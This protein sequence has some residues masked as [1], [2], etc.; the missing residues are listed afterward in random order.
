MK[1]AD[2]VPFAVSPEPDTPALEVGGLTCSS[3]Q[4]FAAIGAGGRSEGGGC[5]VRSVGLAVAA[6]AAVVVAFGAE[7]AIGSGSARTVD[8]KTSA[9]DP[10]APPL[11]TNEC[12]PV[13]GRRWVFP[14]VTMKASSRQYESFA[15]G[16]SCAKAA[17]WT[18]Q[19]ISRRL[20]DRTVGDSNQVSGV[21]GFT[22]FAYPDLSGY[23]YAGSCTKTGG[24]AIFGWNFN[25]L[26]IPAYHEPGLPKTLGGAT[27]AEIDMTSLGAGRY[28]L[29]VR[30]ISRKGAIKAFSWVPPGGYTVTA[31]L[32]TQGGTCS[33]TSGGGI[34]CHGTMKTPKC[35]CDNSGGTLTI[36]LRTAHRNPDGS[37]AQGKGSFLGGG[38]LTIKSLAPVP[39]LVPSTRPEEQA[40]KGV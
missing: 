36:T 4:R 1:D 15:E 14:S 38:Q 21:P 16:V 24:S 12:P 30:N 23:A 6:M 5:R 33:V 32:G 8:T 26:T 35:L 25:E 31:V 7:P 17:S 22:C 10:S 37:P 28:R 13:R 9:G 27:D 29:I 11:R 39:Y 19:L 40:K 2:Y 18:R 34:A 3:M 20:K